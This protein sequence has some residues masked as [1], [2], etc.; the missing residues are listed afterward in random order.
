MWNNRGLLQGRKNI[1][2][3]DIPANYLEAI[4]GNRQRL[5]LNAPYD[6]VLASTLKR[7]C[8]T[9]NMYHYQ[10]ETEPLLDELDFGKFEGQPKQKLL[11]HFGDQWFKSPETIVLGESLFSL[12]ERITTFLEKY[13]TCRNILLFG[14]GAWIRAFLSFVQNG[15]ISEMN[16][17]TVHHNEMIIVHNLGV[18]KPK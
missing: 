1:G 16:D 11:E 17:R 6:V 18:E 8:Q 10:P 4:S 13:K 9:A 12:E 15:T 5:E 3:C 14:H 2:L 7:T